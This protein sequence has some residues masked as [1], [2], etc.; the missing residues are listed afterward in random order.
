M[1]TPAVTETTPPMEE[2]PVPDPQ[3]FTPGW[4]VQLF[5]ST[6]MVA[7]DEEAHVAREKFS[8]PVY[9]EYEPPLYKVRLGNFLTKAAAQSM[10]TRV[11]AEG[12]DAWVVETLVLRPQN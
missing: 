9:V 10:A 4:R 6:S 5:A 1:A 12:Y 8:E 7:A 2:T 11:R 3:D